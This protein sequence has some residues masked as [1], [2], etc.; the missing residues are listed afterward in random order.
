MFKNK[1]LQP[2]WAYK[3][4]DAALKSLDELKDSKVYKLMEKVNSFIE[5]HPTAA[6]M[7]EL[8]EEEEDW[9]IRN[10]YTNCFFKNGSIP[11]LGWAFDFKGICDEYWMK[12]NLTN[13]QQLIAILAPNKKSAIRFVKKQYSEDEEFEILEIRE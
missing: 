1:I 3:F 2:V 8:T 6:T 11:L 9:L 12:I 13:H 4:S 5:K 10:F 7:D